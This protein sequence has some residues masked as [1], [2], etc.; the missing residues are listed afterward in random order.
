LLFHENVKSR[1]DCFSKIQT[2][3]TTQRVFFKSFST[4][5]H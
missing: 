2:F 5:I 3:Q 1:F 4:K